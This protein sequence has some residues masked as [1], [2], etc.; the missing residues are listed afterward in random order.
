[1]KT[2]SPPDPLKEAGGYYF[3]PLAFVDFVQTQLAVAFVRS[4]RKP[5][6]ENNGLQVSIQ[7][8]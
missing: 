2:H 5:A 8:F 4:L 7:P 3:H 6:D 1:M